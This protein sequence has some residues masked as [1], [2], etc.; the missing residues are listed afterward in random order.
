MGCLWVRL[1]CAF[2]TL[3]FGFEEQAYR[4]VLGLKVYEELDL[5]LLYVWKIVTILVIALVYH[6]TSMMPESRCE[7][8]HL[9]CDVTCIFTFIVFKCFVFA[10]GNCSLYVSYMWI[11]N[12]LRWLVCLPLCS[13]K[14][15]VYGEYVFWTIHHNWWGD[16]I[17][18]CWEDFAHSCPGGF[19]R[20]CMIPL[21]G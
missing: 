18:P 7:V 21:I 5:H 17:C 10:A 14:R 13:P 12:N 20:T 15:G 8:T 3:L 19:A 1:F 4:W 2:S 16:L 6:P 9:V 11:C